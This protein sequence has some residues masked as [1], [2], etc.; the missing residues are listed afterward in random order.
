MK[1]LI[2]LLLLTTSIYAQDNYIS[3]S[4]GIDVRNALFG[5]EPTNNKP[6]LDYQLQFAM[7]D[8]NMEV[9]I[10]FEAFPRLD[11]RKYSI[12]AGYHFQLYAYAF[13][14]AVKTTFI[15][16]LEP[17][18]ID[19]YDYWGGGIGTKQKSSH[20]SLGVN[21]A[22]RWDLNDDM[23]FEYCFNMLPRTDLKAMYGRDLDITRDRASI[24]GVPIIGSNY[25]KFVYK[26]NK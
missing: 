20:L 12:G 18:L 15:P 26:I 5:S 21:L 8:R 11:F 3:F 6:A 17:S 22:F 7:V 25:I 14:R 13:K 10:G 24:S 2:T 1:K 16:S 19:R 9:N 23:A 4:A